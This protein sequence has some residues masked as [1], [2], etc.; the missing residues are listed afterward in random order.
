MPFNPSNFKAKA[1][2]YEFEATLIY[3]GQPRLLGLQ[4]KILAQKKQK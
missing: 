3:I 4:R 2:R 1:G